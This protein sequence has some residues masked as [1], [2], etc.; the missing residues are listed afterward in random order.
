MKFSNTS[1]IV[2]SEK[3]N[4]YRV[5]IHF[6]NGPLSSNFSLISK[7][8]HDDDAASTSPQMLV[9]IKA[10]YIYVYIY[11]RADNHV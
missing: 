5:L 3:E 9:H 6:T 1:H 10:W 2:E 7:N 4:K 11:T 8:I